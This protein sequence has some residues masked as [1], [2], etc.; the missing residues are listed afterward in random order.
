MGGIE[1][2]LDRIQ[3]TRADVTIDDAQRGKGQGS[4][5]FSQVRLAWRFAVIRIG[6]HGG[7]S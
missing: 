3:G 5:R 2:F 1:G 6:I 4:A 7:S